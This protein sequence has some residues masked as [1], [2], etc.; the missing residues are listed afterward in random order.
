MEFKRKVHKRQKNQR[1]KNKEISGHYRV[2]VRG[3]KRWIKP[4]SSSPEE[5]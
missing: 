2:K 4:K 5:S 3:R 1:A